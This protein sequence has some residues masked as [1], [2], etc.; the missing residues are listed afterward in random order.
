MGKQSHTASQEQLDDCSCAVA[1]SSMFIF[2]SFSVFSATYFSCTTDLH[3]KRLGMLTYPHSFLPLVCLREF[4]TCD[5]L[6]LVTWFA[7]F[8]CTV[9][10]CTCTW[11][12]ALFLQWLSCMTIVHLTP[13]RDIKD[14]TI[15]SHQGF[16]THL[17]DAQLGDSTSEFLELAFLRCKKPELSMPYYPLLGLLCKG[18]LY[19]NFERNLD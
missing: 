6:K 2:L 18:K 14:L 12:A 3:S 5:S 17:Y 19:R 7:S 16:S 15:R 13:L 8:T 10:F 11:F 4:P 9:F 1:A